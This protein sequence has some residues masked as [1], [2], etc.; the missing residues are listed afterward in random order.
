MSAPPPADG[1]SLPV[2][3]D[4][5]NDSD[6]HGNDN[7]VSGDQDD[8]PQDVAHPVFNRSPP[9]ELE[10]DLAAPLQGLDP[11]VL[12]VGGAQMFAERH[13]CHVWG[14]GMR[15]GEVEHNPH[16]AAP[17]PRVQ[18]PRVSAERRLEMHHFQQLGSKAGNYILLKATLQLLDLHRLKWIRVPS[19]SS[20]S[21]G[22]TML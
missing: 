4:D 22:I 21:I 15:L 20:F 13:Q 5:R 3:S 2:D 10:E 7:D 17:L 18:N 9:P 14:E 6:E 19:L 8:Q 16:T 12:G 11:N 1:N